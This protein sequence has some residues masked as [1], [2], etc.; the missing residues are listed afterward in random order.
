[1]RFLTLACVRSLPDPRLG[2][3][4]EYEYEIDK[5]KTEMIKINAKQQTPIKLEGENIKGVLFHQVGERI[6]TSKLG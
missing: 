4:Y 1:M 2:K 3:P 5:D 6:K